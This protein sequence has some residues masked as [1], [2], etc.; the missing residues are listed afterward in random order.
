LGWA[1]RPARR[2]REE[3][4]GLAVKGL[5]PRYVLEPPDAANFVVDES[6]DLDEEWAFKGHRRVT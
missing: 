2:T 6:A 5:A 4:S 1:A 3:R